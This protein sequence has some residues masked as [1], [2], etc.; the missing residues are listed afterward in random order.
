MSD[1][2]RITFNKNDMKVK[3]FEFQVSNAF[4]SLASGK[5]GCHKER[6][7][8]QDNGLTSTPEQ[9]NEIDNFLSEVGRNGGR[10]VS[11]NENV[12]PFHRH[13]N[14]GC[15]SYIVRYSIFYE[16]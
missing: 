14:G 6:W 15:D 11:I 10:V 4:G 16:L 3:I 13:N 8:E 2:A 9:E 12:Y 5:Y 7:T 1:I